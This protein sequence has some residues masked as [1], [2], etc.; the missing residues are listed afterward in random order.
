MKA[1]A[2]ELGDIFRLRGP[3]Y[4]TTFGDLLSYEQ[5]KALRAIAAC[6][7]TALGGHVDRCD[8]CGYRNGSFKQAADEPSTK[9]I[10]E[11]LSTAP[12]GGTPQ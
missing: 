3:A 4:L 9:G 2:L 1:P 11:S 7:T 8:N 10:R 6:R 5:K 12:N